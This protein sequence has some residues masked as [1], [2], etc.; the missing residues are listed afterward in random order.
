MRRLLVIAACVSVI[1]GV[2]AHESFGR[3]ARMTDNCSSSGG[4]V[5]CQY[6]GPSGTMPAYAGGSCCVAYSAYSSYNYWYR[7]K[8]WRPI[9][10]WASIFFYN[11]SSTPG[12][13]KSSTDNPIVSSGSFGYD[14]AY[15]END[16]GSSL[17]NVT[18]Q[19]YNWAA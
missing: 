12:Y 5:T 1:A 11:G 19:V 14:N 18:C 2:A 8:M 7:N 15:C 10:N 17:P 6:F 3:A 16:T 9:G 4:N 13:V